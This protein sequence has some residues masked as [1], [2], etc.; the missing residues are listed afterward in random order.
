[1]KKFKGNVNGKTFSNEQEYKE[2]LVKAFNDKKPITA[3]L[4]Y[5]E[6]VD[7]KIKPNTKLL[8]ETERFYKVLKN[9]N[10]AMEKNFKF[11]GD[12]LLSTDKV[13]KKLLN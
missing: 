10:D 13:I 4:E 6:V 12:S 2:A 11:F 1:M 7:K 5:E 3:S 8:K 9:F